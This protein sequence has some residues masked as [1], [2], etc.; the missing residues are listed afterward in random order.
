LVTVLPFPRK[1]EELAILYSDDYA[2]GLMTIRIP[3]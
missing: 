3:G 2:S 1:D